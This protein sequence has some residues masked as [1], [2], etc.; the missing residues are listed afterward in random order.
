MIIALPEKHEEES[1]GGLL[2][3]LGLSSLNPLDVIKRSVNPIKTIK[4][5]INVTKE[6]TGQVIKNANPINGIKQTVETT[7]NLT[8]IAKEGLNPLNVIKNGLRPDK[9][10]ILDPR[11][12][13]NDDEVYYSYRKVAKKAVVIEEAKEGGLPTAVEGSS[14]VGYRKN[15]AKRGAT[16]YT[17]YMAVETITLPEG[18]PVSGVLAF[19][20][21]EDKV[22]I[23][24]NGVK[25]F[26]TKKVDLKNA[27]QVVDITTPLKAGKNVIKVYAEQ[28]QLKRHAGG[29]SYKGSVVMANPI[30]AGVSASVLSSA[31]PAK[32][33][34]L[35]VPGTGEEM[36]VS[37]L[38]AY[39]KFSVANPLPEGATFMDVL[40]EARLV[41]SAKGITIATATAWEDSEGSG[42]CELK[43]DGLLCHFGSPASP[44]KY[45]LKQDIGSVT[46]LNLVVEVNNPVT[47]TASLV[48][49]PQ[50]L[51]S[52]S[53]SRYFTLPSITGS[54][55]LVNQ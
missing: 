14:W 44:L 41:D 9:I 50:S 11:A 49:N 39:L 55:V 43:D 19:K 32:L 30:G 40:K 27:A 13:G 22:E 24:V 17:R 21:L 53:S 2:G 48:A 23:F 54:S 7:K 26:S 37:S 47:V 1:D 10:G 16:Q 36:N 8:E 45:A 12:D 31:S 35:S 33:V 20:S 25:V 6:V 3:G 34:E 4:E 38:D 42:E 46:P 28:N 52:K 15:L 18:T 51:M 29:F 5:G